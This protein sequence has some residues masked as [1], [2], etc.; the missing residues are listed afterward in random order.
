[1]K[2]KLTQNDVAKTAGVSRATVSYVLN[3]GG[4]NR[5][6]IS[7]ETKSR[8]L[9]AVKDL[10]YEVDTRAQMLRSGKTKT[11]GILIPDMHNPHYWQY[12]SGVEKAAHQNGYTVLIYHSALN[13]E[14][15]RI[16]FRAL[17]GKRVDGLIILSAFTRFPDSELRELA[18]SRLPIIDFS[19]LDSVFDCLNCNYRESSFEL[20]KHLFDL[21]H[22]KIAFVYGVPEFNIGLDRLEPYKESLQA[23]G[24]DVDDS[25]IVTCGTSI[26]DAYKATIKL[27][28]APSR[29]TAIIA[30][31]D[32]LALGVMRA[33][34]DKGLSIPHDISVASFDDVPLAQ[35]TVPRLTT[36]HRDTEEA[37]Q[38][39]FQMLLERMNNPD[40]PRQE[41]SFS[42]RLI[43][44]ESTGPASEI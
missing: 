23:A 29:P 7:E 5:V 34:A 17:A 24:I 1:M 36:V 31:N 28:E 26:E 39:A 18:E 35:Y 25:L 42:T 44:R 3:K 41:K 30:I 38:V 12:L 15:E 2:K 40:M 32:Y 16:G 8:V 43:V 9:K 21:G 37:G 19:P 11:V 27:L 20:M 6:P 4:G 10:G 14:E 33:V 22:K 13:Q